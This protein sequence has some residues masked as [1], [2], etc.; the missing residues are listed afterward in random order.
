MSVGL[1]TDETGTSQIV[2]LLSFRWCARVFCD[3]Q[4]FV[5][6]NKLV[7]RT[8]NDAIQLPPPP[9][10]SCRFYFKHFFKQFLF[11]QFSQTNFTYYLLCFLLQFWYFFFLWNYNKNEIKTLKNMQETWTFVRKVPINRVTITKK[12]FFHQLEKFFNVLPFS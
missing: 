4:F 1:F 12:F 6:S 5:R 9:T 2:S 11:F 3:A 8:H 10:H 7:F